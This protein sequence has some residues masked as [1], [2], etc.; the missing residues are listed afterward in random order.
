LEFKR[1]YFFLGEKISRVILNQKMDPKGGRLGTAG[2][3]TTSTKMGN[4][5][6]PEGLDAT[7]GLLV[8]R[9]VTQ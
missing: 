2:R 6:L 5:N 9:P 3:I 8:D 1:K 4:V 7:A